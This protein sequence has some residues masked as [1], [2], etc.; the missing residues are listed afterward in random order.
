MI[1][2]L[3]TERLEV[4]KR[5]NPA[6]YQLILTEPCFSYRHPLLQTKEAFLELYHAA[7]SLGYTPYVQVNGYIEEQELSD[8]KNWLSALIQLSPKGF[9]F[10]DFAVQRYLKHLGYA[11]ELV[12]APETI[13]TNALDI[14]LIDRKSVV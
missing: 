10:N 2:F 1:K 8:L 5:F 7:A 13:L 4:L 14:E 9:Y 12:Y 11:G 3:H 6:E